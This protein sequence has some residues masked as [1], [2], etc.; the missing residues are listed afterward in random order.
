MY[1]CYVNTFSF[2]F[3]KFSNYILVIASLFFVVYNS[4]CGK[5]K[6]HPPEPY[7][8]FVSIEFVDSSFVGNRGLFGSLTIYFVDGDGDIGTKEVFDT[9]QTRE[10]TV[11]ID[12]YLRRN[13]EYIKDTNEIQ[14]TYTV[15]YFST[16]GN[17]KTLEGEIV[18][19]DIIYIAPYG[20][21]NDPIFDDTI[22]YEFYIKDRA[23][24]KS[25]VESTG[26]LILKS[27][28]NLN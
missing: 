1:F 26:D 9:I 14:L 28:F 6:T 20:N 12:K 15:P 18:I 25:N 5:I 19:S 17:N 10:N 16:S 22:K 24:N 21:I 4:G 8:E 11:F 7:I 2:I 3:L 23:G 13:N 27:Y